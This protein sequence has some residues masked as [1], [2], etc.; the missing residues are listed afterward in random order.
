MNDNDSACRGLP[1]AFRHPNDGRS[2]RTNL[3]FYT[4]AEL[5]DSDEESVPWIVPRYIATGAIT[6][7]E[8]HAKHAGKTTLMLAV[9]RAV[10]TG[11]EFLGCPTVK[12]PVVILTE[13]RP[14]TFREAL[15]RAHLLTREDVYILFWHETKGVSF[16]SVVAEAITQCHQTNALL[17]IVD[18]VNQFAGFRDDQE[19]MSGPVFAAMEPLQRAAGEGLA[20]LMGRHARKSGGRV[21]DS[22]RGSTAFPGAADIVLS[23]R[24]PEGQGRDTLREIHALSRFE[25]TP[26]LLVIELTP[27]GYVAHG[28]PADVIARETKEA[29]MSALFASEAEA[30]TID[31]IQALLPHHLQARTTVQN[32]LQE[33]ID[34]GDVKRVRRGVKGD[35]Y[36]YFNSFCQNSNSEDGSMNERREVARNLG[37][38]P[39]EPCA[40]LSA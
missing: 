27:T 21:G 10:V 22:G 14:Q 29:I 36:R 18:T 31:G 20:V 9:T 3:R 17:L 39:K 12:T 30:L 5:A 34:S 25:D 40:S 28:S 8:G 38:F 6:D 16:S 2:G 1:Q 33:L 24:R 37:L 35:A 32:T 11:S 26:P 19:N 15:N 13:E 23:L 4:P 7:L